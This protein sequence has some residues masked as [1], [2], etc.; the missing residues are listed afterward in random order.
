MRFYW[1]HPFPR[2]VQAHKYRASGKT[3]AGECHSVC[4]GDWV[5]GK[6]QKPVCRMANIGG[7]SCGI[8]CGIPVAKVVREV[9]RENQ[10]HPASLDF[11]SKPAIQPQ[12]FP[13]QG[14]SAASTHLARKPGCHPPLVSIPHLLYPLAENNS[15]WFRSQNTPGVCPLHLLFIPSVLLH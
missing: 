13:C 4:S 9:E 7:I 6:V 14:Q 15:A 5:E 10:R 11:P 8:S 12:F 1:T 2:S 3:E